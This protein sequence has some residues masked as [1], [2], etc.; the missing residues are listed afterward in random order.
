MKT[1][2]IITSVILLMFGLSSSM[3]LTLPSV[4]NDS[5]QSGEKLRYR[6]TYG[7][8]DAG[9]A[10][11]EVTETSKKGNGTRDLYH[12]TGTGK[13]LGGFNA[14]FKVHDIYESYIDK[15]G[16]FPWQFIRRV[17]EGGYKLSQDYAFKQD[18]QKVHNGEKDFTTPAGIQDMISSFYYARTLNFKSAKIGDTFEFKCFMDDEIWPLKVKYLGDEKISI[19]KGKFN[20]MKFAPVVQTGRVFKKQDD[21]NF[22]VTKDDNHIPVLV[23]A[24]I[25]VGSVKLHL[26]EWS[27]LKHDLVKAK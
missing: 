25:P 11:L 21:L 2:C 22:W 19:R 16:V 24:K 9:E 7:F 3:Q 8:I 14:V 26:V 1:T 5:F 20:C 4:T 6:I 27:G 13:T 10:V 17:E 15:K 12:I 23:K 18:K